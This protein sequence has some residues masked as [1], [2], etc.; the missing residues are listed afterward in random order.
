MVG[1]ASYGS[2]AV[3]DSLVLSCPLVLG[4]LHTSVD[5]CIMPFGS[6]DIV[7]GMDWVGLHQAQIDCRSKKVQCVDDSRRTVEIVG[8]QRPI[9]LC[10]IFTMQMKR[11]A[12]KGCQ[13]FAVRLRDV[14]E[15]VSTEELLQKHSILQEFAGVFPS[16]ILGM[17]PRRDIEFWIDL[18]PGDEP[19]SRAPYR[20][21]T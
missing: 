13:L 21:T 15:E 4:D 17:P 3:V 18:V 20:M 6:Y 10:M 8:I 16:E 9:F 11:C 7:L 5:L 19:I 12:W 2:K 14:D 1:R